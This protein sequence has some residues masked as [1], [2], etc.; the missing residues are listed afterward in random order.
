MSRGNL[1]ADAPVGFWP[2]GHLLAQAMLL[3]TEGAPSNGHQGFQ[4][5]G[6]MHV[7]APFRGRGASAR[8]N[9]PRIE[10]VWGGNS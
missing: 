3:L 7:K 9:E 2:A 8:R 4:V 1:F 5:L 10:V 6:L